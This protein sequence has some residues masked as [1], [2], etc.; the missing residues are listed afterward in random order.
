MTSSCLLIFT[1][2]QYARGSSLNPLRVHAVFSFD[3]PGV[4]LAWFRWG[5]G[6][7]PA[8]EV[9]RFSRPDSANPLFLG[10]EYGRALSR[11]NPSSLEICSMY[12]ICGDEE[13][14]PDT[15]VY[16]SAPRSVNEGLT[17]TQRHSPRSDAERGSAT[18]DDVTQEKF[19]ILGIRGALYIQKLTIINEDIKNF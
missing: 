9:G 12:V 10:R 8:A 5:P 16:K 3:P 1:S 17:D 11:W 2:P 15:V 19:P 18:I 14:V 6:H 7:L 13:V 4:P